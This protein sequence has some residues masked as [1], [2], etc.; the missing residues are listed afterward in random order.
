MT[1][2]AQLHGEIDTNWA[3]H[4]IVVGVD[5][6]DADID[7]ESLFGYGQG[8]LLNVYSPIYGET[9][10]PPVSELPLTVAPTQTTK[11]LGLY[12]QD[13]MTIEDSWIV[14]FGARKDTVKL[15]SAGADV[16]EYDETIRLPG[17]PF[18]FAIAQMINIPHKR[19]M[20]LTGYLRIDLISF[21]AIFSSTVLRRA[22]NK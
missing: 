14:S 19:C 8:G 10:I 22:G 17:K 2:D 1:F 21:G 6:Q 16:D 12:I 11:Q 7:S 5:S 20:R 15:S 9:V 13:Q 4:N 18:V 3:S